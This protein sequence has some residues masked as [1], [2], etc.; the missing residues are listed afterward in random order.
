M[1]HAIYHSGF[2]GAMDGAY[3]ITREQMIRITGRPVFHKTSVDDVADLL[4]P[5]GLILV[6]RDSFYVVVSG[7]EFVP[8][9]LQDKSAP[10]VGGYRQSTPDGSDEGDV[11]MHTPR[12][13]ARLLATLFVE[14]AD[15]LE[16]GNYRISRRA[17]VR[18][19][20]RPVIHQTIIEDIG[21]WLVDQGLILVDR[22]S[23]FVIL[24]HDYFNAVRWVD[25]AALEKYDQ[26][27]V[28]GEPGV[29]CNP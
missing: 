22:D 27:P 20:G 24:R 3:R 7:D 18:L 1:L 14:Q 25:E 17:L 13:C 8:L 21:D 4:L 15:R 28:F 5:H 16:A 11:V 23:Y 2:G 29:L 6:D 12:E 10:L 9:P 19:T 26:E